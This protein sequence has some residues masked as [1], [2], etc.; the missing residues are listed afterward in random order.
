MCC[1][2]EHNFLLSCQHCRGG[3][4]AGAGE[5][6]GET[7]KSSLVMPVVP[8]FFMFFCL[9]VGRVFWIFNTPLS[10]KVIG[11]CSHL[12]VVLFC[13]IISLWQVI[14]FPPSPPHP[15][16]H[17]ERQ[18]GFVFLCMP[19]VCHALSTRHF[20]SVD[21][22]LISDWCCF[23]VWCCSRGVGGCPAVPTD[24]CQF[25]TV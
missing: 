16:S 1:R 15:Q 18:E 12:L 14:L 5:V 9:L 21:S 19:G 2:S 7:T 11:T 4:V 6:R 25:I 20:H 22:T 17:N 23:N 13:L 24:D 10:D 8:F 3:G